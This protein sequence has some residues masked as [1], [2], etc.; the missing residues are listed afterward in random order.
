MACR[1][2]KF[3]AQSVN[4]SNLCPARDQ[5]DSPSIYFCIHLALWF[6]KNKSIATGRRPLLQPEF[7]TSWMAILINKHIHAPPVPVT[8]D[9]AALLR[10]P[11]L[12]CFMSR[13]GV[14]QTENYAQHWFERATNKCFAQVITALY[15]LGPALIRHCWACVCFRMIS[16]LAF[17]RV[18]AKI[19]DNAICTALCKFSLAW[20]GSIFLSTSIRWLRSWCVLSISCKVQVS[21]VAH[22]S[23]KKHITA[24]KPKS[25]LLHVPNVQKQLCQTCFALRLVCF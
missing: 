11:L 8:A 2:A 9:T 25:T 15:H 20:G 10:F 1:F 18:L 24:P 5:P 19:W 6:Q 21:F 16:S 17:G 4:R 14:L 23:T 22:S 7:G 13:K 3:D 12:T